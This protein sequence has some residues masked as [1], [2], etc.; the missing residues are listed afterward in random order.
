MTKTKFTTKVYEEVI[1]YE[2]YLQELKEKGENNPEIE[3]LDSGYEEKQL[4]KQISELSPKQNEGSNQPSAKQ[5]K[6]S[7][8]YIV[9]NGSTF[10]KCNNNFLSISY[11]NS[12]TLKDLIVTPMQRASQ[13]EEIIKNFKVIV[14]KCVAKPVDF[15]TSKIYTSN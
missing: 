3:E 13:M 7:L 11:K 12:Q 6:E 2:Q 5:K 10:L 8:D 1:T 14:P 4:E 9:K 15:I